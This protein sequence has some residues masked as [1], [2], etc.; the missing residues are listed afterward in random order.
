MILGCI[1]LCLF[2]PNLYISVGN[3]INV[4]GHGTNLVEFNALCWARNFYTT[5]SF[6]ETIWICMRRRIFLQNMT[7]AGILNSSV[8]LIYRLQP[9]FNLD[10]SFQLFSTLRPWLCSS[11]LVD[12]CLGKKIWKFILLNGAFKISLTYLAERECG[13]G[14]NSLLSFKVLLYILLLTHVAPFI[15]DFSA[16]S[17][18][19]SM[20]SKLSRPVLI[21]SLWFPAQF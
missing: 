14:V 6:I 20:S 3:L 19:F 5:M 8:Q 18:E 12:I 16:G 7:K 21:I 13:T 1:S 4:S 10:F 9:Y 17:I 15:F 11:S 2:P